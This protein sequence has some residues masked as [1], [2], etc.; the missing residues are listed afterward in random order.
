MRLELLKREINVPQ[1]AVV[2][3]VGQLVSAKGPKGEVK[4]QFDAPRV[5]I[6]KVDSKIVVSAK[7]AT[8]KD[9][10]TIGSVT[11]HIKNMVQGVTQ[12]FTYK[13]KICSGHFPMNVSIVGKQII[14]KNF[15]GEKFPRI[16]DFP[17]NVT[18]KVAGQ[19]IIV[20]SPDK[21][22]AGCSAAIIEILTH[23]KGRDRR[24]FQ[25]GIFIT[26]KDQKVIA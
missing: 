9:K 5:C 15:L 1:G 20:E 11:A 14:I 16:A 6:E 8:K 18:V 23:V 13:L 22:I 26:Q 10:T 3:L 12:G 25:D 2:A 21:E 24:I 17:D 4:R 7:N 19:E